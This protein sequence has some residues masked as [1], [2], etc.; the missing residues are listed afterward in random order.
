MMSSQSE[1]ELDHSL[2]REEENPNPG[3][4][5][6]PL[7]T[8]SPGY[9][10]AA[11]PSL[12]TTLEPKKKPVKKRARKT[13]LHNNSSKKNPP[14]KQK[15][16]RERP[17]K[18]ISSSSES[19][20]SSSTSSS[21]SEDEEITKLRQDLKTLKQNHS[22]QQA[23]MSELTSSLNALVQ[24]QTASL[25]EQTTSHPSSHLPNM[26]R[27][28]MVTNCRPI[29]DKIPAEV[30]EKIQKNCFIDFH[31]LIY[32]PNIKQTKSN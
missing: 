6:Q 17:K 21:S 28:A 15:T 14:K 26:N 4:S 23:Q 2:P 16:K 5:N 7:P 27:T 10:P 25:S 1:E 24:A 22:A 8:D 20:S 19:S 3:T 11:G 32:P 18:R 13:K 29:V 12:S 31:D 30:M 9:V